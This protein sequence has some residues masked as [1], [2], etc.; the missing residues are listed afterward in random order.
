M[1]DNVEVLTNDIRSMFHRMGIP[2]VIAYQ[3]TD[4]DNTVIVKSKHTANV[5]ELVMLVATVVSSLV[6]RLQED[7]KLDAEKAKEMAFTAIKDSLEHGLET[8]K[9]TDDDKK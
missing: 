4:P 9:I 3:E 1:T 2:A 6:G 5:G 8:I 7:M